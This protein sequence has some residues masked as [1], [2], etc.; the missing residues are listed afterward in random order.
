MNKIG[1]T[2]V[3]A[4]AVFIV[5]AA[6]FFVLISPNIESTPKVQIVVPDGVPLLAF[7]QFAQ[8]SSNVLDNGIYNFPAEINDELGVNTSLKVVNGPDQ[9]AASLLNDK[10]EM[11][12]VPLNLAAKLYNSDSKYRL[13]MVTTWGL[14]ELVGGAPISNLSELVGKRI[15]TF[16]KSETPGIVLRTLLQKQ[17]VEYVDTT[18]GTRMRTDAVNLVELA[19]AQTVATSVIQKKDDPNT[20]GM[21]PEPVASTAVAKTEGALKVYD[22]QNAWAQVYGADAIYPQSGLIIRDDVLQN[23]ALKQY[24]LLLLLAL[25]S[26]SSEKPSD[27]TNVVD[28]LKDKFKSNM[29]ANAEPTV[30]AIESGR[31]KFAQGSVFEQGDTNDVVKKQVLEYL[32]SISVNGEAVPNDDFF[33]TLSAAGENYSK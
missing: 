1:V 17:N 5:A 14:N 16:G 4:F 28:T 12:V 25:E 7:A 20:F 19:D 23:S 2:V 11:A 3:A 6:S 32:S 27:P 8:D 18:D 24:N 33:A 22:L 10:P 26:A 9:L 29:F 30:K 13:A 31:I 21:L 15:Y